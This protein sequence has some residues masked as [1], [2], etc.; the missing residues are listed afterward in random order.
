MPVYC[1]RI[2]VDS[3]KDEEAKTVLG[4]HEPL[5]S[6]T[7]FYEVQDIITKRRKKKV[8]GIRI[9]EQ[10]KLPLRGFLI[11]PKCEARL[12]GSPSI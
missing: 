2:F 11:C 4:Q 1:G 3:Y 7:F 6:E 8:Q 9:V 10:E 12:T 5:I